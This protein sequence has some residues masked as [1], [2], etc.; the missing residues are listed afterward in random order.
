[1]DLGGLLVM[2]TKKITNMTTMTSMTG[3]TTISP[4]ELSAKTKQQEQLQWS[5]KIQYSLE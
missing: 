5:L 3:M 4:L 2:A 1:M